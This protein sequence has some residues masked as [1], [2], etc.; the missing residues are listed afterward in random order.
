MKI[1]S[2]ILTTYNSGNKIQE[3]LDSIY[4]QQ[5]RGELF[6]IDLL[7]VDDC[8]IDNTQDILLANDIKFLSTSKNTGGPNYGRNIA[9]KKCTGD[10][11]CIADH[12]DIWYANKLEAL[13]SVIDLAPIVT[14]GYVLLDHSLSRKIYRVK[15]SLNNIGYLEYDKNETFIAKMTRSKTGQETYLG[16][17]LFCQSFKDILFEEEYGMIDFDWVLKL[18][19]NQRSVEIC[20]ALYFREVKENNLSLNEQYR[21]N[22]YNHSVNAILSYKKEYP[23][24][25]DISKKRLNG[26]MGRY[27]YLMDNM[28]FAR[29][30]LLKSTIEF[31]TILYL[32]TTFVGSRIVK[33][34]FKIFG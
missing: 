18:F 21:I 25:V 4:N 14:S 19:Y 31:K 17:I 1:V 11:I 6:E 26:S 9:L 30:Y 5:R 27:Y 12:D 24:L 13:L 10:Y 20:S 15:Q 34:Y 33:R 23:Y 16:S 2:I 7:V 28:K 3:V 22:D 32:I 29:K 8:S